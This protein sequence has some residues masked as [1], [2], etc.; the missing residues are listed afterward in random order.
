MPA[1]TGGMVDL[2]PGTYDAAALK[3]A[4]VSEQ[5]FKDFEGILTVGAD[6]A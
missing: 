4:G 2:K 6:S 5:A 1:A 3:A